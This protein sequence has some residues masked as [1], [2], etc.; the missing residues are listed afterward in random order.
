MYF[1]V[2]A[3]LATGGWALTAKLT[4]V[5]LSAKSLIDAIMDLS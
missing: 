4:G 2:S 3:T 5:A 1:S